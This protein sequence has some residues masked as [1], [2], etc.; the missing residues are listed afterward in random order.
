MRER[1]T[2][3]KS[4][5]AEN[6]WSAASESLFQAARADHA[7]TATDRVRV[8]GALMR[9][10]AA[11]TVASLTVDGGAQVIARNTASS[12][13]LSSIAKLSIGA[14]FVVLSGSLALL[15]VG[16]HPSQRPA[17]SPALVTAPA[18][19]SA[20]LSGQRP[21]A[22]PA[23]TPASS[24]DNRAVPAY[25]ALAETTSVARAPARR[26]RVYS[27]RA[28]QPTPSIVGRMDSPV[29]ASAGVV[30]KP[31]TSAEDALAHAASN[32]AYTE[33][34]PR[35]VSSPAATPS[36]QSVARVAVEPAPA[37]ARVEQSD[38][39]RGELMLVERIQA[40]M[41]RAK[42]ASAL[43]LCAEHEQRW[44]H[45]VF[46]EEREG[47]RAIASCD[48]RANDAESRARAFLIQHARTA[49]APRVAA[50]CEK[51]LSTAANHG[52]DSGL[53]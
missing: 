2:V 14:A 51:Q 25:A 21:L 53:R 22:A 36:A 34:S 35:E 26:V 41:R 28:R 50:A 52:A 29:A 47:V 31:P 33:T 42:P 13:T 9:R 19:P 24:S 10:L 32:S 1:Y 39:S 46:A 12:V 23:K 11:G 38:D 5:I 6:D 30:A 3:S 48:T 8:R 7:A 16:G 20:P 40:A 4:R 43:V 37:P 27:A 45:G 15:R 44:P 49:L 17:T 18:T